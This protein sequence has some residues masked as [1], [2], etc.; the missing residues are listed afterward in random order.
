MT[1]HLTDRSYVLEQGRIA[2]E[3]TSTALL[4]NEHVQEAYLALGE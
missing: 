2:L 4:E 1:L 3:G